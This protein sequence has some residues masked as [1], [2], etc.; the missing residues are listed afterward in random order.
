MSIDPEARSALPEESP[1]EPVP[2][3]R[4]DVP[5]W[6]GRFILYAVGAVLLV[7]GL[8]GILG[9]ADSGADPIHWA[10]LVVAGA[11]VHDLL[12]VPV[13]F[14]VAWPLSHLR[15]ALLRKYLGTGL[16]LS[17]VLVVI[18]WPGLGN[19]GNRPDN[20]SVLPLDYGRGLGVAL[21]VVWSGL[22]VLFV[23]Q[24]VQLRRA[25]ARRTPAEQAA[26][27]DDAGPSHRPAA[28]AGGGGDDRSG[29][30]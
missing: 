14:T 9:L 27:T 2:G 15:P 18:A 19:F 10:M 3:T 4:E 24:A 1:R 12:L 5:R 11:V 16:A 17:G 26:V 28:S 25:R 13:V 8:Q 23:V 20:P 7:Y 30:T 6:R 29:A 21:A 22:L